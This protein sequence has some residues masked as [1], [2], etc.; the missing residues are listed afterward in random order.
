MECSALDYLLIA[1][2]TAG[3]GLQAQ[4]ALGYS[5]AN[6]ISHHGLYLRLQP[7]TNHAMHQPTHYVSVTLA[8]FVCCSCSTGSH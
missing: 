8:S 7:G 2:S 5:S 6:I 1:A 3:A 4:D